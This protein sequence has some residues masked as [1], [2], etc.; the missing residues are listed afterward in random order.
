VLYESPNNF[1]FTFTQ[2]Q[3]ACT[4][5]IYSAFSAPPRISISD[6]EGITNADNL[7][8]TVKNVANSTATM[9]IRNVGTQTISATNGIIRAI[10]I[11]PQ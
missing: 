11:G 7:L 2:G 9:C 4:T 6:T 10:I 5:I 3:F 8:V 1:S